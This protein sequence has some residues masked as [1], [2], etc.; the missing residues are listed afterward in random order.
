VVLSQ[1]LTQWVPQVEDEIIIKDL[2][3][4]RGLLSEALRAVGMN[5]KYKFPAPFSKGV[6]LVCFVK[7]HPKPN[8]F[9]PASGLTV[10]LF[11]HSQPQLLHHIGFS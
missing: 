8:F 2:I 11:S 6:N 3:I 7:S 10:K 1:S 4:S 9:T 5:D